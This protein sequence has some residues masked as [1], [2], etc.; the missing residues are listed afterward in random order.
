MT[1]IYQA[2]ITCNCYRVIGNI[3][4]LCLAA[5]IIPQRP[6]CTSGANVKYRNRNLSQMIVEG[7]IYFVAYAQ[8]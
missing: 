2:I 1:E 4:A 3:A 5:G 8:S 6:E 7:N